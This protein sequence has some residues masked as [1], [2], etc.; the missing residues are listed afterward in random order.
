MLLEG[1]I[2]YILPVHK[3]CLHVCLTI[4]NSHPFV[5]YRVTFGQAWHK[6]VTVFHLSNSSFSTARHRLSIEQR[7]RTLNTNTNTSLEI[8]LRS[9]VSYLMPS[10]N[11]N[12]KR[13]QL[14]PTNPNLL[15]EQEYIYIMMQEMLVLY[16]CD[17]IN[18][19]IILTHHS[20]RENRP[21][22]KLF[23]RTENP[24]LLASGLLCRP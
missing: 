19:N 16:Q 22:S 7:T 24:A 12:S 3:K 13:P 18:I 8:L 9:C 21:W 20:N 17:M 14:S 4:N 6:C 1:K 5:L 2:Y 10:R 11:S 15:Q 23:M